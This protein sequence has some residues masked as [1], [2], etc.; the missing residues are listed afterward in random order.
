[1][2]NRKILVGLLLLFGHF[3]NAQEVLSSAGDATTS[4]SG[5]IQ[6]TIGEPVIETGSGGSTKVTQGFHQTTWKFLGLQDE[7][8]DVQVSIYPNPMLEELNLTISDISQME[9][10]I[11]YDNTGRVV[12]EGKIEAEKTA[13]NVTAFAAGQY[14][15]VLKDV[16][17]QIS[18]SYSLIKTN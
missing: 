6:Y 15:L 14:Q 7:L 4:G 17:H 1:M 2:S 12:C 5:Y 9:G 11:I 8:P 3:S 16:Q 10:F 13:I 18:K